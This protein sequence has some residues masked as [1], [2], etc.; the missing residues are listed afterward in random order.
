MRPVASTAQ[1]SA[2]PRG[3]GRPQD[4]TGGRSEGAL[5]QMAGVDARAVERQESTQP[6][7]TLESAHIDGSGVSAGLLYSA[8]YRGARPPVRSP[9]RGPLGKFAKQWAHHA[10]I[11]PSG[12]A[13]SSNL[14][15]EADSGES[16][17]GLAGL[18]Q[19][20]LGP[21]NR[22]PRQI[23]ADARSGFRASHARPLSIACRESARSG[24][25]K[26]C[27]NAVLHRARCCTGWRPAQVQRVRMGRR[28]IRSN[29]AAS[30]I[31]RGGAPARKGGQKK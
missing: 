31:G 9:E 16:G 11:L 4:A 8:P 2:R 27:Q 12:G 21:P 6:R 10:G 19:P 7:P 26:R 1:R 13:S 14:G 17:A 18:G 24:P 20:G 5:R 29:K 28:L 22:P 15:K 30:W 25:P 23:R 3:C